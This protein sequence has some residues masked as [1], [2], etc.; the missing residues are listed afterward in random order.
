MLEVGCSAGFF[1]KAASE[2]GYEATG[3]DL[4]D[5]NVIFGQHFLG[6]TIL[7]GDFLQLENNIRYDSYRLHVYV[8]F[9]ILPLH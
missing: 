4:G 3:I 8:Y 9:Y 5:E 6:V 1:L 7:N 2:A